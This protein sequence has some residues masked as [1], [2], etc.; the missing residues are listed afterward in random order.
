[1]SIFKAPKAV[2]FTIESIRRRFFWGFKENERKIIWFRWKKILA[3]KIYGGLGVRSIKAKNLSLLGKWRWRFLNEKDTLWRKVI[4][5]IH[6]S[7]GGFD[8][9]STSSEHKSSLG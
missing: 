3:D 5:K 4:S 9:N 1:L 6:G 8:D 2:I 7:D